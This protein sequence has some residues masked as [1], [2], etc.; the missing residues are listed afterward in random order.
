MQCS[1]QHC[2]SAFY[3]CL[4]LPNRLYSSFLSFFFSVYLSISQGC[5]AE[6]YKYLSIVLFL[7][8]VHNC[9]ISNW[10]FKAEV[11]L[12]TKKQKLVL[13]DGGTYVYVFSPL[14]HTTFWSIH[15][16]GIVPFHLKDYSGLY[17]KDKSYVWIICGTP[18][19]SS[20]VL[21]FLSIKY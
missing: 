16:H 2:H 13:T 15:L 6:S 8:H 14:F 3:F 1:H 21:Y 17:S 7:S 5:I 12:Q 4:Y 9:H 19:I 10:F 20:D 18:A 11:S